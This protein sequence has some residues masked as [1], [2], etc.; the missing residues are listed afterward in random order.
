MTLDPITLIVLVMLLVWIVQALR[1][2][3]S[4]KRFTWKAGLNMIASCCLIVGAVGFFGTFLSMKLPNSFEWPV[5]QTDAA[6][7]LDDGT[8]IVP[9]EPSGRVQI[10]ND[11]LIFQR[12]WVVNGGGGPFK[13]TQGSDRNF[14]VH[15]SRTDRT[16]LYDLNGNVLS[17]ENLKSGQ[18]SKISA[19]SN[20]VEVLTPFYLKLFT[21]PIGPWLV[22]A[23]G[24]FLLFLTGEGRG[25][26][27]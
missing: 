21:S 20:R 19:A 23:F 8:T 17:T 15:A 10:Y 24:M 26:K 13:L 4:Q 3:L 7:I 9:H 6:I 14:Y 2:L 5:G 22:A 18:Y 25:K 12:G 16:Y 1:I 27:A 11:Q